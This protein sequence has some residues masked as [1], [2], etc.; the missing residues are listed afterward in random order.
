MGASGASDVPLRLREEEALLVG[1]TVSAAT[2]ASIADHAAAHAQRGDPV[3]AGVDLRR[4]AVRALLLRALTDS[5]AR[6]TQAG[7]QGGL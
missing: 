7:R 4:R 1:Q 3:L 2:F 6:A 5:A